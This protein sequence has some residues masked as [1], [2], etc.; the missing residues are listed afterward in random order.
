MT[1]G[2]DDKAQRYQQ[3]DLGLEYIIAQ[4]TEERLPL[5]K[6]LSMTASP[7]QLVSAVCIAL[8]FSP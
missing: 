3:L 5:A 2:E 6:H 4:T 8:S 1:G 7:R